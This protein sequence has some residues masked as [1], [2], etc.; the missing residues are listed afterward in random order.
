MPNPAQFIEHLKAYGYHPRSNK[1]SDALS[2]CIVQ[3]FVMQ[4]SAAA[5]RARS[6]LLVYDLNFSIFT[7]TAEWRIDLVFGAPPAGPVA[8]PEGSPIARFTPATVQIAIEHKAVMTEHHKAV[9]NRKRD[10]EAHHTNIRLYNP[11]T[12][13]GAILIVNAAPVFQSPLRP[14]RT[15][16]RNPDD[17]VRHCMGE[18]RS[19]QKRHTVT[20]SGLDVRAAIAVDVDNLDPKG[21]RYFPGRSAPRVGDPIHYD[22]FMQELCSLYQTRFGRD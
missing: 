15:I 21:Y 3:D 17:L 22:S 19:I 8:V 11:D 20:G 13:S 1:H 4:C 12:I 10:F 6:G 7:G 2:K 14:S 5:A 18:F 9:K 16:H